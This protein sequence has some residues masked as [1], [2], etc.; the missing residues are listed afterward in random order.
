MH[1]GC[2]IILECIPH[3][4]HPHSSIPYGLAAQEGITSIWLGT[5]YTSMIS[6]SLEANT[7]STSA[8]YLS[9]DF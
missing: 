8:T 6:F 9:V 7:L 2:K 5:F 1:S 3:R 4:D